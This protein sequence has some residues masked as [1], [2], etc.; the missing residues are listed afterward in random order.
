MPVQ[1]RGADWLQPCFAQLARRL[2]MLFPAI[3]LTTA[4]WLLMAPLLGLEVGVRAGL[5]IAVGLAT[6]VLLPLGYLDRRANVATA[7]LG[8]FMGFANFFLPAPT[9]ALASFATCAVLLIFAG[10]PA[11]PVVEGVR[12]VVAAPARVV[13]RDTQDAAS[14]DARIAA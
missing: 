10:L 11:W 9:L 2:D 6:L 7:A 3:G 13:A 12:V 14:T 1:R 4:V 8:I 5:G